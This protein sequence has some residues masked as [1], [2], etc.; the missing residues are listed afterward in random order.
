M[1]TKTLEW[2]LENHPENIT[3]DDVKHVLK[4]GSLYRNGSDKSGRPILYIKPA[5]YNPNSIEDRLKALIFT[6]EQTINCRFPTV[7]NDLTFSD[8]TWR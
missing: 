3:Y 4:L 8:A 6:L 7:E 2:R 5:N 1:L